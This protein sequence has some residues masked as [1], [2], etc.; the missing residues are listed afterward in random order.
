MP[1][2]G[3][4]GTELL[5]ITRARDAQCAPID[6][7]SSSENNESVI[8][9]P[10]KVLSGTRRNDC[11]NSLKATPNVPAQGK[12]PAIPIQPAFLRHSL[13]LQCQEGTSPPRKTTKPLAAIT[14]SKAL[15]PKLYHRPSF[16][17]QHQLTKHRILT[18]KIR[19]KPTRVASSDD[20][21]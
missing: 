1:K 17:I 10:T 6:V 14:I 3:R 20:P 2:R 16:S 15:H 12:L 4:L 9:K 7:S 13:L 8:A 21:P 5:R 11:R 18:F 19:P